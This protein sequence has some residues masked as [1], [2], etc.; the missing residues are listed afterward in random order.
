M[1]M[2]IFVM[3]LAIWR[4]ELLKMSANA[5]I[6]KFEDLIFWSF[7]IFYQNIN[8][9]TLTPLEIPSQWHEHIG[10]FF[11]LKFMRLS[12]KIWLNRRCH[13]KKYHSKQAYYWQKS[14]LKNNIWLSPVHKIATCNV[15]N[16]C[17][18]RAHI[19]K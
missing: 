7:S 9:F 18:I 6:T 14:I 17:A 12:N 15:W 19:A 13:Q 10:D 4:L 2:V 16:I 3:V 1:R 11:N 5:W 8:H